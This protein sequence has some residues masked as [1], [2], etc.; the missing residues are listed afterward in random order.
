MKPHDLITKRW[1][2]VAFSDKIPAREIVEQLFEAAR[3]APS[4]YN[5]QPWKFI[6]AQRGDPA[7]D[8]FFDLLYEGNQAWAKTAPMLILSMAEQVPEG[9][10]GVN[11]F[12]SHDT[13]MATANLLLQV[14]AMG[15]YAHMM[16]GYD[17]D[18]ARQV[19]EIPDNYMLLAMIAVGYKGDPADLP[20]DI[21]AREKNKRER[22][23]IADFAFNSSFPK[24]SR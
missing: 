23:G 3:W 18:K 13:G 19:L 21:A 15:M 24:I 11:R 22:H 14:T 9:R 1:S 6:F 17:T 8:K 12:A 10:T 4:S 7:Y 16:G 5:A 2:P 20:A